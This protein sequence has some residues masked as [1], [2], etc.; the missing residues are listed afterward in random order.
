MNTLTRVLMTIC[1]LLLTTLLIMKGFELWSL[2]KKVDGD[3]MGIYFLGIEIN[4]QVH[5]SSI[6]TYAIGFF[7]LGILMLAGSFTFMENKK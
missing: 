5:T 4:D 7:C 1:L 6:T 3:G 2:S